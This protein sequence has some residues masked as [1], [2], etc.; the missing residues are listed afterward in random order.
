MK[1]NISLNKISLYSIDENGYISKCLKNKE[2]VYIIMEICDE[3]R[4]YIGSSLQLVNRLTS[5]RSSIRNL[6]KTNSNGSP[7]FYNSVLK[8]GWKYFKIGVLEYPDLSNISDIKKKK[9]ILLEREQYYLNKINPSLNT[10][11]TAGSPLGIKLNL[12]F[13]QNVSKAKRGKKNIRSIINV[14]TAYKNITSETRS[15]LSSRAEGV[16]VKIYDKSN[17]LLY[18]FPSMASAAKHFGVSYNTISRILKT[19]ISYDDYV[20]KFEVLTGYPL[21]VVNKE[22]NTITEYHSISEAAKCICVSRETISKYI[23]IDKLL[24]DTYL[25]TKITKQ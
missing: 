17:N 7:M 23:N 6:G 4:C 18:K 16:I 24:K 21:I 13:L 14:N 8:Y 19:G 9:A 25:I 2:A 15:K 11:K 3:K 5:H 1:D 10:C 20:Y 12:S 22:K